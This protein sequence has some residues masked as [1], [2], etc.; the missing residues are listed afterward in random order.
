MDEEIKREISFYPEIELF[1]SWNY[2][3][4]KSFYN[5]SFRLLVK[6]GDK[7]IN[8]G[9]SI[10]AIYIIASGEFLVKLNGNIHFTLHSLI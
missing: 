3:K 8:E 2:N 5:H 6:K 9:D 4:I 10:D 1:S 7:I